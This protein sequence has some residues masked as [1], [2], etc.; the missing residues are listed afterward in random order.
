MA[1]PNHFGMQRFQYVHGK[2][3]GPEWQSFVRDFECWSEANEL[4]DEKKFKWFKFY[5][6]PKAQEILERLPDPKSDGKRGPLLIDDQSYIP[7]RSQYELAVD[8]LND[9]FAPLHHQTYERQVL[10]QMQQEDDEK[11]GMFA[12]RLYAQAERCKFKVELEEHVKDQLIAKCRS[13]P[14]LRE[15][16]RKEDMSYQ[17]VL[18]TANVFE[19]VAEQEK[20]FHKSAKEQAVVEVHQIEAKPT[21][22][23]R[24]RFDN[25]K[26]I[27]CQRCGYSGH[28]SDDDKCPAQGKN[29]NKCGGRD[30]FG[31][32]CYSKKRARP[33]NDRSDQPNQKKPTV[34]K[35]EKQIDQQP[36]ETVKHI[37]E[38]KPKYVFCITDHHSNDQIEC[39]VGG[40]ATKGIVDS[41][42][43]Y[44]LMD[45]ET[46]ESLK[47]KEVVVTNQRQETDKQFKAYGGH[48]LIIIG[49][50]EA[51]IE[52]ADKSILAEFYVIKG[53]GKLLVG[54]ETAEALG[55]L[56]ICIQQIETNQ[57]GEMGKIKDVV[58]DIPIKA[59]A[60]GVTQPYRRVP[61]ALEDAVD[62]KIDELL[63]QGII[64]AV[65]GPSK[66]ISPV[67]VVPKGDDVR[68]CVDM[69]RAN[70]AVQ[71]ENHPLPTMED[72]LPH[73]GKG[74]IFSKLD[75]KNAFH[76]VVKS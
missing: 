69:R 17:E 32:K 50:F 47:S 76:Q 40:V 20:S 72:F 70:E 29:C 54:R 8:K 16:L 59:N 22:K 66:W 38:S 13:A 55:I 49:V 67:V 56:K 1:G 26:T 37:T 30:H 31:R 6:G 2:N 25:T 15:M 33:F 39:K 4:N 19:A 71:R 35:N 34:T 58:V 53:T 75:I 60:E 12:M 10:S 48:S 44:N 36:A 61:V 51:E 64:E 23:R 41:G 43:K 42:S 27:E 14:L 28:K 11:V 45:Q 52:I 9:H 65:N 5:M 21:W 24:D 63:E 68:I 74:K 57:K 7:Q 73:I 3:S 62:K 18:R 46:W